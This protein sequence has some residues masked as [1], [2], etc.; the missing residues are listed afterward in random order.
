MPPSRSPA[1][2]AAPEFNETSRSAEV[3]PNRTAILSAMLLFLLDLRLQLDF[4]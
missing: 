1:N 2:T 4:R 3:P